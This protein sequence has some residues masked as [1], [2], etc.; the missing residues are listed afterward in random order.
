MR[1]FGRLRKPFAIVLVGGVLAAAG[2]YGYGRVTGNGGGVTPGTANIWIN[3]TAGSSPSRCSTACAYDSTHAYGSISAALTAASCGDVVLMK[4]GNYAAQTINVISGLTSCGTDVSVTAAPAEI[5]V[6]TGALSVVGGDHFSLNGI[7]GVQGGPSTPNVGTTVSVGCG[8]TCSA[9]TNVTINGYKGVKYSISGPQSNITIENSEFGPYYT[10]GVCGDSGS[11]ISANTSH[12]MPTHITIDHNVIHDFTIDFAACPSLHADCSHVLGGQFITYTDNVWYN[13]AEY[14]LLM[15]SNKAH[16]GGAVPQNNTICNNSFGQPTGAFAGFALRGDGS[17]PPATTETHNTI[18]ICNNTMQNSIQA[19]GSPS[20]TYTNVTV[21]NNLSPGFPCNT[22]ATYVNNIKFT[23]GGG[24]TLC[25]GDLPGVTTAGVCFTN[26]VAPPTAGLDMSIGCSSSSVLAKGSTTYAPSTDLT[27]LV[28]PNLP[29]VGAYDRIVS[30]TNGASQATCS[31][32]GGVCTAGALTP[33]TL[34]GVD[35]GSGTQT[36]SVTFNVYRPGGLT[37]S[38]SNKAA[39]VFF[40]GNSTDNDWNN[41][42]KAKG[43]P[44]IADTNKLVVVQINTHTCGTGSVSTYCTNVNEPFA[45][46]PVMTCGSAANQVCN[47]TPALN[48]IYA[49]V[50]CD[51]GASTCQN[52]DP[53][54]IYVTG[55]SKGGYASEQM[56]CDPNVVPKFQGAGWVSS[57]VMGVGTDNTATLTCPYQQSAQRAVGILQLFGTSD[58]LV[59]GDTSTYLTGK[60]A[61]PTGCPGSCWWFSQNDETQVFLGP[62][63]GCTSNSTSTPQT[64]VTLKTYA[65]CSNG[66]HTAYALVQ[67]GGHAWDGLNC[68]TCSNFYSQQ[69]VFNWLVANYP[70]S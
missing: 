26:L 31:G 47:E 70:G 39:A 9:S 18:L 23:S 17:S 61:A 57:S 20:A 6:V 50:N 7:V 58:S 44:G 55:A 41:T 54:R 12:A 38:S 52:I 45:A 36:R 40:F 37:N 11:Q 29:S 62:M 10:S 13:C 28:R 16:D 64:G 19:G 67:N 34:T 15:N 32:A 49:A 33:Y 30:V 14:D 53:N 42:T 60:A 8:G 24:G 69:Y 59:Y 68:S 66:A 65:G 2:V 21:A 63:L 46:S 51:P 35:D 25:T 43:W 27:G 4:G 3:L 48:A 1:G 22:G 56:V 5:P